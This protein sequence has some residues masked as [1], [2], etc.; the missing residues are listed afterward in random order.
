MDIDLNMFKGFCGC[1]KQHKLNVKD[2]FIEEDA[3]NK[4]PEIIAKEGFNNITVICDE[5][6]YMVAGEEIR[7]YTDEAFF[8]ELK[9]ENLQVDEF[10]ISKVYEELPKETDALIA[11]GAGTIHDITKYI[12]YNNKVP[13]ISMPTAAS[14]DGYASNVAS[15]I[16]KGYKITFTAVSPI[17]VIADTNIFKEAPY[18]LTAAGVADLLGKYTALID[19]KISSIIIGEYICNRICNLEIDAVNKMCKYVEELQIGSCRAYEQLM[20]GLILSGLSVQIIGNTR[21]S[22]GSEHHI[23]HLW[24]MAVIN[25]HIDA[26]H[27]E[28]VAVA[29]LIVMKEYNKI[30]SAIERDRCKVKAYAGLDEELLMN[31]FKDG[32]IYNSIIN[33]NTPD[34]LSIVNKV[35]LEHRLCDIAEILGKLPTI[36]FVEDVLR[37]AKAVTSLEEIGLS[38]NIIEKTIAASPYVGKKLTVMRLSKMM[39]IN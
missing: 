16:W 15:M 36:E 3:I 34:P 11:L 38:K 13:F 9:A 8:I 28:K 18:R 10:A 23:A 26:L 6:T 5:N 24:D 32:E 19:W 27:G 1:G 35:T 20:Y 33:E 2:I 21:P 7:A 29:L 17:Y 31:T 12:A 39:D 14:V 25:N 37:K 4:L 30:K 22:A